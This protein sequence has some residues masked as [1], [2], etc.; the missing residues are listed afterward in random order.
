MLWRHHGTNDAECM[1]KLFYVHCRRDLRFAN[2]PTQ[3]RDNFAEYLIGLAL[4]DYD[5][6][7]YPAS[8]VAAS[9][10]FLASYSLDTRPRNLDRKQI[11]EAIWPAALANQS[12][13]SK[14]DMTPCLRVS[15]STGQ[16][17][18]LT[19]WLTCFSSLAGW[20]SCPLVFVAALIQ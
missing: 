3:E 12:G 10:V 1:L 4:L 18:L 13:Y 15:L 6:L 20:S 7:E 19:C 17:V 9:A 8:L 11:L 2:H 5:M 16:G 14:S